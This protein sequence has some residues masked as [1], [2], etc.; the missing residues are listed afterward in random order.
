MGLLEH[1]AIICGI[2]SG[3]TSAPNVTK[4]REQVAINAT[5][6]DERRRGVS[7]SGA[8]AVD[9]VEAALA[10]ALV[11]ASSDGR[12]AIVTM[13]AKELEARRLAR[14]GNVVALKRDS[15]HR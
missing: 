3:R 2:E 8:P 10:D 13:L 11:R 1:P 4:R 9:P 6:D 15:V 12:W 5:K 14:T 7:A